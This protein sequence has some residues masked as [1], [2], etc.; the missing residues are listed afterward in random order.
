MNT[1]QQLHSLGFYSYVV[2]LLW[3][4]KILK[5][6]YDKR[7]CKNE[8]KNEVKKEYASIKD[9]KMLQIKK[10]EKYQRKE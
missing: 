5:I 9:S 4:G 2:W 1:N 3:I 7:W 8:K 10:K 6:I